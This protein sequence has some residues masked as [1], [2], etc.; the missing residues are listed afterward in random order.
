MITPLFNSRGSTTTQVSYCPI[1]YAPASF[2]PAVRGSMLSWEPAA[3]SKVRFQVW[4]W[5]QD[6]SLAQSLMP[7][8]WAE[9]PEHFLLLSPQGGVGHQKQFLKKPVPHAFLRCVGQWCGVS[10]PVWSFPHYWNCQCGRGQGLLKPWK[11]QGGRNKYLESASTFPA[12][13]CSNHCSYLWC[14]HPHPSFFLGVF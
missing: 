7:S 2:P 4:P 5:V 12:S 1:S 14:P 8:E 6:P 11:T 9:V 3:R 13:K 10:G